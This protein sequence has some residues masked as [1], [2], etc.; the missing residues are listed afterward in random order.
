M[1]GAENGWFKTMVP[2]ESFIK[3]K[4]TWSL[5]ANMAGETLRKNLL[6]QLLILL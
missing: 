5:Q 4:K 1:R 3:T 6:N 2:L